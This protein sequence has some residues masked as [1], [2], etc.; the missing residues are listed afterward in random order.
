RPVLRGIYNGFGPAIR[1][2]G[3]VATCREDAAWRAAEQ[4]IGGPLTRFASAQTWFDISWAINRVPATREL[5]WRLQ[6]LDQEGLLRHVFVR[7]ADHA[8]VF[9]TPSG[10]TFGYEVHQT[11]KDDAGNVLWDSVNLPN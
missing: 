4:A 2:F 8:V 9:A 11:H 10:T 7:S 5:H 3:P 1:G 6:G